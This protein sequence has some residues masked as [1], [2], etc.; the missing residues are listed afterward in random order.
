MHFYIGFEV[1]TA[2]PTPAVI[3]RVE[4]LKP[5]DALQ[6]EAVHAIVSQQSPLRHTLTLG[7]LTVEQ[8]KRLLEPGES[9]RVEIV[10]RVHYRDV[11]NKMRCRQFA[12]L[13]VYYARGGLSTMCSNYPT[14]QR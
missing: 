14:I 10:G 4:L 13:F 11:F 8:Q 3:E 6:H 1:M 12:R 2:S 7:P 9:I 5:V